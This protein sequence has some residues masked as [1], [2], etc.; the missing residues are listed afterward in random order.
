MLGRV[1]QIMIQCF[2]EFMCEWEKTD[3]G[4]AVAVRNE[5]LWCRRVRRHIAGNVSDS[6]VMQIM[7]FLSQQLPTSPDRNLEGN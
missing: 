2:Y 4:A 6:F 3:E 5:P 1:L 7:S